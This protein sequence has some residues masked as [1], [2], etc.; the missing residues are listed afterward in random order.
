[1]L[2]SA[3]LE[4][5]IEVVFVH[6]MVSLVVT[7][8]NELLTAVLKARGRTSW[9]GIC[10]LVPT[11]DPQSQDPA[12]K[13]NFAQ[14]VY[15]HPLIDG[16]SLTAR[17]SYIP[18]RVFALVL[19]DV[20]VD[21]PQGKIELAT[22]RA[23]INSLPEGLRKPLNVL[24]NES[25]D[26]LEQFKAHVEVWFNHAM[27]RV[28]GWY[29]RR[30]QFVIF[31][32]AVVLT[33]VM[34]V[35]SLLFI[36]RL[37][38]DTSLRASLVAK[39]SA[40][41]QAADNLATATGDDIKNRETDFTAAMAQLRTL[42]LTIGWTTPAPKSGEAEIAPSTDSHDPERLLRDALHGTANSLGAVIARHLMGWLLTALAI[43]LGAPFWFDVLNRFVN[44][45]RSGK[46]PEEGLQRPKEVPRPTLAG[47]NAA[48]PLASGGR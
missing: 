16:L 46:A 31:G 32:I 43:S 25:G 29:K 9:K 47:D 30:V 17:L 12:A 35:D 15:D 42:S 24:L 33:V 41:K 11:G 20:I 13:K 21:D 4:I 27:D 6:L 38:R 7:A 18:S 45:R 1:M 14:A 44:I 40:F 2:G 37:S 8:A 48:T 5:A 28:S 39:A 22:L 26:D 10:N 34:N 23:K 19:L 3:I 36:N